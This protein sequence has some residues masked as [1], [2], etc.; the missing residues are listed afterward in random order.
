METVEVK[1]PDGGTMF[2]NEADYDASKH[3]KVGSKRK[4][5]AKPKSGEDA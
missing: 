2:I 4:P 3:E 5:K 1:H